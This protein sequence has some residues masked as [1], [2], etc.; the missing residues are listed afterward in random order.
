MHKLKVSDGGI[1]LVR[2]GHRFGIRVFAKDAESLHKKMHPDKPFQ[3]IQVQS[4]YELRPLPYGV[5]TAGVRDLLKQWGWKAKVLQPYKA[6][7][8]G[9]GWLIGAESPPPAFVFQC[10]HGDVLATLHKKPEN[11]KQ[12]QVILSSTKTKSMLKKTPGSKQTNSAVD[13]ENIAPW[14]GLDPWGGYNKF[15]ESDEQAMQQPRT[16]K[17]D[18]LQWQV[19][20]IV[21]INKDENEERFL[22]LETGI[23]ELRQQNQKFESWFCEAGQSNA[24]LKQEMNQLSSQVKEHQQ[25][26][27]CMSNDIRSGFANIEALLSKKQRQ[28]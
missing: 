11:E 10:S 7:Q 22:K 26:I 17:Y 14:S 1:S 12:E 25:S 13:K 2:F 18:R 6:D 23:T 5:Q 21:E 27:S 15:K 8:H 16:S 19:Q 4:I 20:D 9:Q 3:A 28:E 24:A